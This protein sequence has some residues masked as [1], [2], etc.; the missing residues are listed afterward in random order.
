M[1]VPW[2]LCS[3]DDDAKETQRC[4][5]QCRAAGGGANSLGLSPA[6]PKCSS[7]LCS[8]A[9]VRGRAAEVVPLASAGAE[10]PSLPMVLP[11]LAPLSHGPRRA[12][13]S[14]QLYVP[15]LVL[16]TH[17]MDQ[18]RSTWAC[19][20]PRI[21]AE[22]DSTQFVPMFRT[23]LEGNLVWFAQGPQGGGIPHPKPPFWAHVSLRPQCSS[24]A[25]S[26][27]LLSCFNQ[28]I[29]FISCLSRSPF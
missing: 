28:L 11:G 9:P 22:I 7:W 18:F 13:S 14:S 5:L 24:S 19:W 20:D 23:P 12:G 8:L 4:S 21:Q 27:A 1:S 3:L 29:V 15:C 2:F 6:E 10:Q 16:N 25:S 26:P 17:S